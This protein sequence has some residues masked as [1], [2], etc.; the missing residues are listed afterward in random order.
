MMDEQLADHKEMVIRD[1]E[2]KTLLFSW[3]AVCLVL[4]G[5]L[6]I[7]LAAILGLYIVFFVIIPCSIL[8]ALIG[9][10]YGISIKNKALNIKIAIFMDVLVFG[11]CF[12]FLTVFW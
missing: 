8:L 11:V 12:W 9:L 1:R 7:I 2:K 5:C 3:G 10:Y 4:F 6:A